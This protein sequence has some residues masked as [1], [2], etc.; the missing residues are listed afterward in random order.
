MA[1]GAGLRLHHIGNAVVDLESSA[2]IY[3]GRLGY[4]TATPPIHE[5]SQTAWVQFLQ[6]GDD[7]VY[8]EL[9]APDGPASKLTN[10]VKRGGGLN[11]LCYTCGPIEDAIEVLETTGMKLI[12]EPKPGIAF[13]GRRVCW[14]L[15]QEPL[16]IELVER[17]DDLD[18]CMPGVA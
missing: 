15:G 6:L 3:A 13:G 1:S 7:P 12:S 11:H 16:P 14:L 8:L 9:V 4:R 5:P 17:R 2:Q 18:A 10:A